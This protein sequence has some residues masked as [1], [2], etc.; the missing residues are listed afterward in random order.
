MVQPDLRRIEYLPLDE[1][2]PA[3]RNP[4]LHNSSGL[5]TSISRF[6]LAAP[7]LRDERTGRLVVGHG[8]TEAVRA[9]R[10]AGEDPPAGVRLNDDGAWL[11]PVV[12]GWASRSDAEAEA[13]L[14]ADNR[15]TELGGW[16]H[17][18]LADLLESI[19]QVD[20]GLVEVTG[21]NNADMIKLLEGVTAVGDVSPPEDFPEYDS[22]IG[23]EHECPS[24]GYQWSGGK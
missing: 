13:Y 12:C 24:C 8:R 10:G 14:I 20:P 7:A 16:D 22:N 18:E 9:M 19:G 23:T 5:I 11:V 15:H 3:P 6:G 17:Q 4:K 2:V 21:Y 1:V